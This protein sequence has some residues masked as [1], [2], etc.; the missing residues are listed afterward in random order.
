[1]Y[2]ACHIQFPGLPVF[3]TLQSLKDHAG[4]DPSNSDNIKRKKKKK[5]EQNKQQ[6]MFLAILLY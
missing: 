4:P 1:M 6:Q 2:R 3:L 5:K